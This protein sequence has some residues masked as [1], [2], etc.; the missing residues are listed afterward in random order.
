VPSVAPGQNIL[1]RPPVRS[2][3]RSQTQ[4]KDD[5]IRRPRAGGRCA[6]VM[7]QLHDEALVIR[8][9]LAAPVKGSA[10]GGA[11]LSGLARIEAFGR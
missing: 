6:R 7:I 2:R 1:R 9:C 3:K 11:V 8:R 5:L 4:C 10:P